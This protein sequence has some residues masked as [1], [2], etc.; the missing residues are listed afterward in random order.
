[1]ATIATDGREVYKGE[2][3]DGEY[4]GSGILLNNNCEMKQEAINDK[5][6]GGLQVI[7]SLS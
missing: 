2:W 6:N 5:N 1:M 4:S 3:V 7:D